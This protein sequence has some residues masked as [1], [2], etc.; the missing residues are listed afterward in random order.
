MPHPIVEYVRTLNHKKSVRAAASLM[1]IMGLPII[2]AYSYFWA[3]KRISLDLV[4]LPLS[5]KYPD[6][7][8]MK[9][10]QISDLHYGPTN[11]DEK[12]FNRA[13]DLI[14]AQEPDLVMLTGDYY[15]WDPSYLEGLPKLL[16][17]LQAKCG[18][19]GVFGNHD[20]GSCYPGTLHCDPFDH[21]ILKKEFGKNGIL[22]LTNENVEIDYN[23]THVNIVGMHDLWSG[24]FD[25]DKAFEHVKKDEPTIVLSHNPDTIHMIPNDF[26]LM[27]SG[28]CHGGQVS[29]PVIGCLGVPVKNKLFKRGLHKISGDKH[30]YINRGLGHNFKM[31]LNSPP[32]V[33]LIEIT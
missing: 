26:D 15:Q 28:H 3:T 22:M 11:F 27:M 31:R 23:G 8:G 24:M 18:V 6:L 25:P 17:R 32:E 33:T 29:W 4:H 14:L 21:R 10:C 1:V 12:H 16:S 30:L 2:G 13:I 19:Y 7:K 5:H 9:I 20:Y